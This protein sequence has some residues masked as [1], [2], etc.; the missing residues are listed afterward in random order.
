MFRLPVFKTQTQKP[1]F[2]HLSVLKAGVTTLLRRSVEQASVFPIQ[3]RERSDKRGVVPPVKGEAN[4]PELERPHPVDE[5]IQ[6]RPAA[7]GPPATVGRAQ[8]VDIDLSGFDGSE[9]PTIRPKLKDKGPEPEIVFDRFGEPDLRSLLARHQSTTRHMS[10][11]SVWKWLCALGVVGGSRRRPTRE[12]DPDLDLDDDEPQK[13]KSAHGLGVIPQ[14]PDLNEVE[15]LGSRNVRGVGAFLKRYRI[16]P[17]FGEGP[18]VR[19]TFATLKRFIWQQIAA[20]F[21][22]YLHGHSK[23]D[24][25]VAEL[26]SR[27]V[28]WAEDDTDFSWALLDR[29]NRELAFPARTTL[30]VMLKITCLSETEWKVELQ[31]VRAAINTVEA[32]KMGQ[33][34]KRRKRHRHSGY[35]RPSPGTRFT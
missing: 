25:H 31:G 35:R 15:R 19:V 13:S 11:Q 23:R 24:Y 8:S 27:P 34:E 28:E 5:G 26:R 21:E 3:T 14:D 16:K 12:S 30:Y 17:Y 1:L 32:P 6:G 2:T 4:A 18:H 22:R 33:T 29:F 9:D 20:C 10:S 7:Q